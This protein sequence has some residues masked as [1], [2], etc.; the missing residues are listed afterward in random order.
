[1]IHQVDPSADGLHVTGQSPVMVVSEARIIRSGGEWGI[2]QQ[3]A[4]MRT[5]PENQ[6][7]VMTR[8]PCEGR[9][10]TRLIPALG[11]AG[12][13]RFHDEL[14][15]HAIG[16]ASSFCMTFSNARLV[17]RLDGGST[18]EGKD[19]LG[20]CDCRVQ[21][22]GDLG[23][24][25]RRA[26]GEAFAEGA[27]RVLIIGTDCPSMDESILT[28]AF[29]A[30]EQDDLVYG[31]AHDGGY[32]LIGMSKAC[33]EVFDGI[34]WGGGEVLN[35]SLAAAGKVGSSVAMLDP[36]A[37]VD[38]PD[39]LAAARL[40][41][42]AGSSVSVI[43][44]TLN[45]EAWITK[46]LERVKVGQPHEIIVADGGSADAT[47][48]LALAGGARVVCSGPGRARQMNRAAMEATGEFLLFLHADTMP[49]K[50]YGKEIA[51]MLQRPG[52][53]AGAF[54]FR[55]E[56][57]LPAAPLIEWLVN[58]RGTPYGD[59]GL[60]V[61]RSVFLKSVGFPD[62]PVMEDL[63]YVRKLRETGR[64][65]VSNL[66]ATTSARRW[67]SAGF[68]RTLVRHQLMLMGLRLGASPETLARIFGRG[69]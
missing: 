63:G 34:G 7:I 58:H 23:A 49:P 10:K 64:V 68:L 12:A 48:D 28:K 29:D 31:P 3:S 38:F 16:R 39:D 50:E 15:R 44:P 4:A 56:G 62:W 9:N 5:A 43:I 36:L 17:V 13:A 51:V 65:V 30:L 2:G 61:R 35:Q 32:Y 69:R 25:M 46:G 19:W 24:R 20:E 54:R 33:D 27:S 53:V 41:L 26:A 66:P 60:F 21:G 8:L 22:D 14:A 45:E 37:D 6:L 40:A 57:D 18:R 47:V 55:L 67:E 52:I 59:Q 1:M 42:E 11:A